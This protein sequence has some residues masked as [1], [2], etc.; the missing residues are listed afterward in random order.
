MSP[1]I[2]RNNNG[3]ARMWQSMRTLRRFTASEVASTADVGLGAARNYITDLL[4]SGYLQV[5]HNRTGVSG[6]A[7]LYRLSRNTGPQHP[8]QVNLS[9]T[10]DMNQQTWHLPE[11]HKEL[12]VELAK[13]ATEQQ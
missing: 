12:I 6:Q 13:R 9:V 1:V 2:K 11:R 4:G 3:R 5:E 10:H 7:T 8:V